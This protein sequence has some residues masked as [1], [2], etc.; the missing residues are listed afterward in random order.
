MKICKCEFLDLYGQMLNGA[1]ANPTNGYTMWD[2]YQRQQ[3]MQGLLADLE[4]V[5]SMKG[6]EIDEQGP[7]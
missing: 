4:L 5:L 6:Y 7:D 3:L 1:M 2:S